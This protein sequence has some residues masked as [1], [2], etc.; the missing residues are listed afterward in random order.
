[1]LKMEDD[2]KILKPSNDQRGSSDSAAGKWVKILL[3]YLPPNLRTTHLPSPKIKPYLKDNVRLDFGVG[4]VCF[5]F[6]INNNNNTFI[7]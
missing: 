2:V 4:S 7:I 6:I 5:P 1:M 3:T